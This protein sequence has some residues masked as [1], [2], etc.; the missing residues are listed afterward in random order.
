MALRLSRIKA[1]AAA[2]LGDVLVMVFMFL[3]FDFFYFDVRSASTRVGRGLHVLQVDIKD[4]D[5]CTYVDIVS[6]T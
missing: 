3:L 5:L 6:S 1:V 4:R 2:V